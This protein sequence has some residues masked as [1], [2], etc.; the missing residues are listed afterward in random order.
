MGIKEPSKL[1]KGDT[2]S[3]SKVLAL[4]SLGWAQ[5]ATCSVSLKIHKIPHLGTVLVEPEFKLSESF[6][7]SSEMQNKMPLKSWKT[8]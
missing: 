8:N 3:F 1:L 5:M 6:C 4:I 7:S 2:H